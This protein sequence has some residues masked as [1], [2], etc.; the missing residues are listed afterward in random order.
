MDTTWILV[1]DSG[2]ARIFEMQYSATLTEIQDFSNS[3]GRHQDRELKTDKEG[4]FFERPAQGNTAEPDVSPEKHQALLFAQTISKFLND[5][6][7]HQRF[8]KLQL[9][10]PP[11]FLGLLRKKLDDQVRK[12]VVK[13]LPKDLSK[14]SVKDIQQYV[15]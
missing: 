9:I 15:R 13:E 14:A 12:V 1:A 6:H 7:N 10:V 5:S 2:R 4:R 11:E 8:S 3:L